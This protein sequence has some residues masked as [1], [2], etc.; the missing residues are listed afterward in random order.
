MDKFVNS[1]LFDI[2]VYTVGG[3]VLLGSELKRL[4]IRPIK[5]YTKILSSK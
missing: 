3:I 4:A 2:L 1:K 5:R